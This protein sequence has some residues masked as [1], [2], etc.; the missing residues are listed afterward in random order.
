MT[1]TDDIQPTPAA[2]QFGESPPQE[3]AKTEFDPAAET[4]EEHPAVPDSA[5]ETTAEDAGP[6]FDDATPDTASTVTDL[7][8]ESDGIEPE[9]GFEDAPAD[10]PDSEPADGAID[11]DDTEFL[12]DSDHAGK[13]EA[14]PEADQTGPEPDAA[15][16]KIVVNCRDGQAVIGIQTHATD[17]YIITVPADDLSAALPRIEAAFIAAQEFWAVQPRGNPYSAPESSKRGA[18]T[19]SRKKRSITDAPDE[20]S[21]APTPPNP[22]EPANNSGAQSLRL[23]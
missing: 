19:K 16:E 14:E 8:N 7:E 5:T 9:A 12:Q 21:D 20:N 17:P 18:P 1:T 10:P 22:G 15:W 3:A 11:D 2:A 4:P 23:F 13:D 6:D